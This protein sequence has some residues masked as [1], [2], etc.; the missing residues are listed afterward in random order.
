MLARYTRAGLAALKPIAVLMAMALPAGFTMAAAPSASQPAASRQLV[1]ATA[2]ALGGE[3][4]VR[5]VRNISMQGFGHYAYQA[6]GGE[7]AGSEHAPLKLIAANDLHR[8]TDLE[9]GRFQMS[10]RRSYLFPFLAVN[11]YN[12]PLW[13]MRLDGDIAWN[14]AYTAAFGG[15]PGPQPPRRIAREITGVDADGVHARRMWMMNNPVVLVRAAMDAGT[16]LSAPRREGA[17]LVVDLTLAQ[18]DHLSAGFAADHLP[19][20]VRWATPQVDLGQVTYTTWFSGYGSFGGLMMPMGYDTRLDWRDI[21]YLKVYVD[22]YD[23]DGEIAD[24]AAPAAVRDM[25]EPPSVNVRPVS[26]EKIADHLWRLTPGGTTVIEF[27]DHVTLYEMDVDSPQAK[28]VIEFAR[29]LVPGK[30]VTQLI[31]SHQH[32]DHV[33]GLRQSVAEGLAVIAHRPNEQVFREM[34]TH[35]A[36]E[37]PDDLAR[38]PKPLKFIPVD[39]K[40]VLSDE[41]M[42]VWVLWM[43]NNIHMADGVVAYAPA[44]KVIME[45][46]VAT[47]AA[48]WQFWP[49]SLRDIIDHYGLDVELDS[50]V[51][52]ISPEHPGVLTMAQ[53]D[54]LIKAGTDRARKLC[55]DQLAN[56]TWMAGCPVRSKRY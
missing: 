25:P 15:P 17:Y 18:G 20:F 19:A 56:G 35:P 50:P 42:S 49:D 27:K 3:A 41:T 32:F 24:L 4:R 54:E 1:A 37:F 33:A 45:G 5:A 13:D 40:L 21:D 29:K 39:D 7:I 55:A 22:G 14:A 31:V 43:R 30:P 36:P 53:V 28:A 16:T 44:Q 48:I 9:H 52:S 47:A 12:F 23:V 11:A 2:A 6:G 26:A 46:D 10:E 34:A 51:H 38:A 8:V